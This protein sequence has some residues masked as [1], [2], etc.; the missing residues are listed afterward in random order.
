MKTAQKI[1]AATAVLLVG[2][3]L[4]LWQ[5]SKQKQV[6]KPFAAEALP[7]LVLAKGDGDGITRIELSRPDDN[8]KSQLRTITIEKRGPDWNLTFPLQT[9]ASTSKVEALVNNLRNLHV[10]EVFHPGND[11]Y[12]QYD[13]TDAKALHIVAWKGAK[14]VSD[15]YCGKSSTHGQF[16]RIP[17]RDGIFS[18]V[19]GGPEG[20]QGFL[21]TRALRS[22]R[23]TSIFKFDEADAVEV[24]ITNTSGVLRF[25]QGG[26]NWTGWFAKRRA[27]G[28]IAS[29]KPIGEDF[30]EGKVWELLRAYRSLE[31]DDFGEERD[32]SDSGVERAE[33]TGG[34]IRIRLKNAISDLTIRVGKLSNSTTRWA[35]KDSRWAMKDGG[36]G[37]LYSLSPWTAGWATADIS[38]FKKARGKL[39]TAR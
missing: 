2:G 15:L 20:Y 4:P 24:E 37:T 23:E 6:A 13:L 33:K 21:Y 10:W 7:N 32:K 26:D 11:W 22:W 34:I 31:A 38:K 14:K 28:N 12:E 9:R 1:Y 35:I 3:A 17:G 25:S 39:R 30:D 5:L 16:V 19:N 36:D 18:L 8:D 29:G 27:N